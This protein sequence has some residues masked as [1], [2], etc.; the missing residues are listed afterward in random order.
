VN[1]LTE[2]QQ[3][4][5]RHF[6]DFRHHQKPKSLW[7]KPQQGCPVLREVLGWM[8]CKRTA[9]HKAGDHDIIV[10]QTIALHKNAANPKPL[11]YLHGR[12]R[13]IKG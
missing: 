11:V 1:I 4:V 7:A 13:K 12:Y 5:S 8:V 9:I 2:E 3:E 6:A 10:G